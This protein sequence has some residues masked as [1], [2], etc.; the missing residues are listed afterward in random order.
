MLILPSGV[1]LGVWQRN[2]QQKKSACPESLP[3]PPDWHSWPMSTRRPATHST[4]QY[5]P[6]AEW[7]RR[8]YLLCQCRSEIWGTET[9]LFFQHW[10]RRRISTGSACF[11]RQRHKDWRRR[12]NTRQKH[13][14]HGQRRSQYPRNNQVPKSLPKVGCSVG[15]ERRCPLIYSHAQ[16]HQPEYYSRNSYGVTYN[17]RSVPNEWNAPPHTCKFS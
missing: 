5:C 6:W 2:A 14:H 10:P 15:C 3:Q 13:N 17:A 4:I 7:G 16:S 1:R 11:Q 8:I 9:T 12:D